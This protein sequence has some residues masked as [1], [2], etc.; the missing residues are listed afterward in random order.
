MSLVTAL[1][2]FSGSSRSRQW[3]LEG[4]LW[5]KIHQKKLIGLLDGSAGVL[6]I[7]KKNSRLEKN[8]RSSERPG[9][10]SSIPVNCHCRA[11]LLHTVMEKSKGIR[12]IYL[13]KNK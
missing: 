3:E 5:R 4:L 13:L 12:P 8:Y 7:L 9:R 10:T 11:T 2:D 1:L 6:C